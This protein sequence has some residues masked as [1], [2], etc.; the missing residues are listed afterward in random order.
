[1]RVRIVVAVFFL[2]GLRWAIAGFGLTG[3]GAA[4]VAATLAMALGMLFELRRAS[5]KA[6]H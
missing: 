3:A 6:A 2:A 5:A 1:L 4:L